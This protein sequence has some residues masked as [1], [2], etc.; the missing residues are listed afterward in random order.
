[1][2]ELELDRRLARARIA[3]ELFGA[4]PEA[5][6]VGRFELVQRLG[7]GAMGTVY[8]ALDAEHGGR[9]ALKV[10]RRVDARGVYR[11]KREFRSLA[12]TS[13]P[14]LVS[15]GELF[16]EQSAWF[17][18]MELIEQG[19]PFDSWVRPDCG[20]CD[21]RR[22]RDALLQLVTAVSA[23]HGE[24]KL[25][26]DLKPS[27]VLVTP[28]GRVIVLDFGLVEEIAL[29]HSAVAR[30]TGPLGTPAY[31]APEQADGGAASEASDWYAVGVMLF[32]ALTGRLPFSG[33]PL[34]VLNAKRA[35][36]APAAE[37]DAGPGAQLEDLCALCDRLL[38]REAARRPRAAEVLAQL[39]CQSRPTNV[40][41]LAGESS[42]AQAI[43]PLFV[44]REVELATMRAAWAEARAG[45]AVTLLVGGRSGVG[46]SALLDRF[47]AELG[48]DVLVLRGRCH[49]QESVPYKVFDS[50]VGALG[51]HLRGLPRER[52]LRLV[53][54]HVLALLQLFPELGRVQAV[55]GAA[56][57]QGAALSAP[58]RDARELRRRAFAALKELLL[59][60]TDGTPVVVVVD[61]LQWGDL[62]SVLIMDH[63][64]G[65]PDPTPLLF[66]G[67]FRSEEVAA[68]DFLRSLLARGSARTGAKPRVL[69]LQPLPTATAVELARALLAHEGVREQDEPEA[70]AQT[71]AA[72]A[73]GVPFFIG[74]LVRHVKTSP[75]AGSPACRRSLTLEQA[76]TE[77]VSALSTPAQS[78]LKVISVA[79]GPIECA[80]A[81][82]AAGLP[83]D[84]RVALQ[85]L[86]SA[87]LA[88]SRGARPLDAVE[89]YHDRIR[90]IVAQQLDPECKR[91]IHTAIAAAKSAAGVADPERLVAHFA[92]AGDHLRAGETAVAAARAANE[93]LA[94]SRAAE[95]Y[96]RGVELLSPE[97]GARLGLYEHLGN[98]LSNAGRGAQAAE[99]FL[100]A[101]RRCDGA[102]ARRLTRMAIQQ[103]FR[104]GRTDQ[105]CALADESFRSV[106]LRFPGT[107]LQ[108]YL[109]F[110]RSQVAIA[111]RRSRRPELQRTELQRERLQTL[112]VTFRE[113][114]MLDP[115]RGA[116]L[117]AQFLRY[118]S[119]VHDPERELHALAWQALRAALTRRNPQPAL[120]LLQRV[121]ALAERHPTPYANAT[122]KSAQAGCALFLRRMCDVVAPAEEAERIL[123]EHC[124][125]TQ[126]EQHITATYRYA[127]IEQAGG[128]QAILN[129]APLRAREA[130]DRD[131]RF[132]SA[133]LTLF[134][135][136]T[137]VALDQPDEALRFLDDQERNLSESLYNVFQVWAAIRRTHT[138]L[139]RGD[140]QEALHRMRLEHRRF[141]ASS[142]A[143]VQFYRT[144]MQC[145]L[146]R[147][148]L[149]GD[150]SPRAIAAA[151]HCARAAAAT[152]RPHAE[153]LALLL[154]AEAAHRRGAVEQA[155]AHLRDCVARAPALHA[156]MLGV[157]AQRALGRV[158]AGDEGQAWVR[159]ADDKLKAEG[160]CAPEPW[161]RV[162][163]NLG[164]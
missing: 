14:N 151:E 150:G 83:L 164:A 156:P 63:V 75:Q 119:Q 40:P 28:A 12:G 148:E 102:E 143:R 112:E 37:P 67:A 43:A 46:K 90:E 86:R 19:A 18:S 35:C 89:T 10:L 149:S 57:A 21:E 9:V 136:F 108:A 96:R 139:Y 55:A 124:A 33:A 142:M 127:A 116:A 157:Y 17:F 101:A 71:L 146:A 132:G 120:D 118:A 50:V 105:A 24:G 64:L 107:K 161:T 72:E 61:D 56:D 29:D 135:T 98:A 60:L 145:L 42:G 97:H 128:F 99:A 110:A 94:F 31:L 88:R 91:V 80:F 77:R 79:G 65:P 45:A 69:E 58:L 125:G 11:L 155:V 15:L 144:T 114:S 47:A 62:D 109:Q 26:C 159:V 117:Q 25:H 5:V 113:L 129:E 138:L 52:A 84:D 8:E 59:R 34:A 6:R 48:D 154:L 36:D 92:G 44:G 152:K 16:C 41:A 106:G 51:E 115:V 2:P 141:S 27:N 66:V 153:A 39:R 38:G 49:E 76:L 13:H 53:P 1:M 130:L 100:M 30:H 4:K 162:W 111:A 68:S 121:N 122:A 134:V 133:A 3:A 7:R 87:H 103:Y 140:A 74:E 126:W 22:L 137:H 160:V 23:L 20:P 123:R 54:R 32:E 147:C 93:K 70:M 78:L 82:A 85:A 104:S 81:L 131:D 158:L 163:I 95:L 73:E